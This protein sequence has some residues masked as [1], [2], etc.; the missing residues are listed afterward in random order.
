MKMKTIAIGLIVI[1]GSILI[2]NIIFGVRANYQYKNSI[3][4]YWSLSEKSATISKKAE[5]MDKFVAAIQQ[6]GFEGQYNSSFYKTPNNSYDQNFE[7]LRSLQQRLHEIEGMDIRSFE[8]Q[9]AIQQITAQEQGEADAMTSVFQGLWY[10]NHYV[11]LWNWVAYVQILSVIIV[12]IIAIILLL[13]SYDN[14]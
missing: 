5:Y 11:M 2:L 9:T 14:F 4:S 13:A 7:A 6:Q 3:E 10:K 12:L 1:C 8:Y